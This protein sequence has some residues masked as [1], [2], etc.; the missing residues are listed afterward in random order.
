MQQKQGK[1][2]LRRTWRH[3]TVAIGLCGLAAHIQLMAQPVT[4]TSQAQSPLSRVA[5]A[6]SG[7]SATQLPNG[8][9]LLLGGA[10]KDQ[11]A[12]ADA[13]VYDPKTGQ[14]L[15][16]PGQLAQARTGHSATLLPDGTVLVIGGADAQGTLLDTAELFD[17][18]AATSQPLGKI[19]II[20]RTR[21]TATLLADGRVLIAGGVDARGT[22]LSQTE[23]YNPQSR[24]LENFRAPLGT[25]RAEQ[26]AALLPDTSV[27]LWGGVD[28][29][30]QALSTGEVFDPTPERFSAVDASQASVLAQPL[31]GSIAP[32]IHHSL[33]APDAKDVAL[34]QRLVVGFTK[35]MAMATLNAKTV[36]LLGPNGVTDIKPVPVEDGVLLFV[37]PKQ[38]LLPGSRYTLFINGATDTQGQLLPF[39]AIGFNTASIGSGSRSAS[40]ATASPSV[41][42]ITP[43]FSNDKA[44]TV[45]STNGATTNSS[46]ATP[47]QALDES[48]E[49]IP[50]PQHYKGE[51]RS[52]KAHLA[53]LSPPK[54]I[55]LQRAYLRT[56]LQRDGRI[57]RAQLDAMLP[58]V[59][60]AAAPPGVTALVGQTLK[61]NGRPL[62]GVTV[63]IGSQKAVTDANGEFVLTNIPEGTPIL[64]IDGRSA[65]HG[66]NSYGRYFH[67]AHVIAGQVNGMPQPIW[68]VKLDSAHA[69]KIA[70]PT[71]QETVISN[72]LLPGLEIHLPAGTVI[73]DADGKVV[74]EVSLTPVPADQTPVA[75]PYG[76]LPV[77]YTLQPGGA[78]IQTVSGKPQGAKVVY[79]NYS[80]QPHGARFELFDYDPYGR[81]WYVYSKAAVSPDDKR[82]IADKDFVIYQ[83]TASSA[84]SSGGVPPPTAPISCGCTDGDPISLHEGMFMEINTD[85][86]EQDVMPLAPVRSYRNEDANQRSFGVGASHQYDMYLYY[87]NGI[88]PSVREIDL[89]LGNGSSIPFNAIGSNVNY[90]DPNTVYQS[91]TPGRF[92]MA[93]LRIASSGF[94]N[95]FL[96]TLKDGTV[97][98]FAYSLGKL[99]SI[100]DRWGNLTAVSRDSSYRV[101]RLTSPNGRTLDFQYGASSCTSCVTSVSDMV[102]RHVDYQYDTA[103]HLI[104]VTDAAGNVTKYTYDATTH[105]MLTVSDPRNTAGQVA[106]PK[107]TNVYYTNADGA[108]LNG[109]IKQ[110]TYADGTT[111]QF[112]YTFDGSGKIIETDVT[113]ER[114]DIRRIEYDGNGLVVRETLAVGMPEQQVFSNVWDGTTK[115]LTSSTD[116]LGRQT[117]YTYD[118]QGNTKSITRLAGTSDAATTFMTY[119]T[120]YNLVTSIKDPLGHTTTFS[121]DTKGNLSQVKDANGNIRRYTYNSDGQLAQMTDALGKATTLTYDLGDLSGMTDPL[122]RSSSIVNDALGRAVQMIDALGNQTSTKFDAL[123]RAVQTTN[124]LNQTINLAFDPNG[125]RTQVRD[126]KGNLHQYAYDARNSLETYTDPLNQAERY[127]YDDGHN[128]IRKTDRKGQLTQY[129]YDN[130]NRL[131]QVTYA[132]AATI[133]YTY[134]LGNRITQIVDSANGT[135]TFDYDGLDR[136]T[137][138]TTAKGSVAYTYYANGLRKTMTVSGQPTLSYTYDDGNRLTRIDQAAGASNNNTPQAVTF[139]YDAANRLT[140][141]TLPNGITANYSYDDAGQ[142]TNITFKKPDASLVGDLTYT[143]DAAGRRIGMGG[144]L[145]NTNLPAPVAN[146]SVDA[147]NRL[148]AWN[149]NS[150]AYDAN[151]NLTGDGNLTYVWNARNQLSQIKDTSGNEVARFSYDALGRRQ[152]K[153]VNGVAIG[154]VYDGANVVQVLNGANVDNS[155]PGNVLVNYFT[156]LGIDELYA[157]LTGSGST[158]QATSY[159]TDAIG[160]TLKLL[161]GSGSTLVNYTYDPYGNVSAD[162]VNGNPFQYTGRENDGTGLYYYRARYY[163]P[164][165]QRFIS[166]DPIGLSGGINTYGYALGQPTRYIDPSGLNSV[167][168]IGVG[169]LLFCSRYPSLCVAGAIAACRLMGGCKIPDNAHANE[170]NGKSCPPVPDKIVGDQSDPRAGTSNSGNRH[171]SGPLTPENGGT[172]DA[173]RDFD[174]LTGGTGKPFPESDSRSKN[175]GAQVGDNGIWIRPD[176][177]DGPRI[178]IPGNGTKLPETL[179]Y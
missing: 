128:L 166:S 88:D 150:L 95:D 97:Y 46:A 108:N 158:A 131:T 63:S 90:T 60:K 41:Q 28:R 27:L 67:Y 86:T 32:A 91:L 110:Q 130:L 73:R 29:A 89:V 92:Y 7:Q 34:D 8:R 96:I 74:T 136:I 177:R 19:G 143:Y 71:K 127:V 98:A 6:A 159:L 169:A 104:Q 149:S 58:Q 20:A 171:N 36:T 105:R 49:W 175:P 62:A 179:H 123:D 129:S 125:N 120:A 72:P 100:Q 132:D 54:Y 25:A 68:M 31:T 64:Q 48:E 140:Q 141:K 163:S 16:L 84:A 156:G 103:G 118:A 139:A 76:E 65:S 37:T 14:A 9:W 94:G 12:V 61:F 119:D 77:Y 33:P 148:T 85:I 112:A 35:R 21:H 137:S 145:A 172:G 53:S 113:H 66:N 154:Y 126:P 161:D 138:V 11:T 50:G 151:G 52:G 56:E 93:Q 70:S 40:A 3:V 160:S 17:P 167:G 168:A 81:G 30:K 157:A 5:F 174:H 4:P 162:A 42:V 78:V 87:P 47:L 22:A 165:L 147:A 164:M 116:A 55:E 83:F 176:G 15:R 102:G 18:V 144:S 26:L 45:S 13:S 114:G 1:A 117:T 134:D 57:R 124:A 109:R 82:I 111:N 39:T 99:K 59:T 142:L 44:S 121:Y 115:L 38:E 155:Q 107:V 170:G 173:E 24:Q 51:W 135:I 106:Q 23:Q 152:S 122:N 2:R 75:M 146:V 69:V 43:A 80:T 101:S 153:I 79:P 133:T 178:E 10:G